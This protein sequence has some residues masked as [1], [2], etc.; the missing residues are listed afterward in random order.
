M[1]IL[2]RDYWF[3][4]LLLMILT[5]GFYAFPLAYALNLYDRKAWY[6]NKKYWIFGAIS[7]IFPVFIML[8]VFYVQ[9]LV[10]V[11]KKLKTPGKEIYVTPYTWILCIICPVLGWVLLLTMII[12]LIVWPSIMIKNN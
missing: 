12:Y 8:L 6:F 3:I 4:C 7:L 1:S 2:K 11:N 5:G 10:S 9:I